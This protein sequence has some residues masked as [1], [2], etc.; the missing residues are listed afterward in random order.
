M[1]A[2]T[3]ASQLGTPAALDAFLRGVER[4]AWVMAHA[5]C[6]DAHGA[7]LA[8]AAT[9][10]RFRHGAA[11]LAMA[12]WP[13]RLWHLLLERPE[14]RRATSGEGVPRALRGLSPGP[15]AILL[16][17]LVV[18]LDE[19]GIARVMAVSPAAV[20]LSM[21]RA[22]QSLPEPTADS[23]ASV[24][25]ELQARVRA[26][27]SDRTR[28]LEALRRATAGD[29]RDQPLP[30]APAPRPRGLMVAL[31]TALV[32][33][34]AGFA[35]TF[36]WPLEPPLQPGEVRELPPTVPVA[37]TPEAAAL[38]SPDFDAAMDEASEAVLDDLLF[39]SW[40][41]AQQE[42]DSDAR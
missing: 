42:A 23:L 33:V 4:R 15:R 1:P 41:A 30:S 10:M 26:L 36:V 35:A 38:A 25:G 5:Q 39:L 7:E 6:G 8:L 20:R 18:G 31:W 13:T 9:L 24:H 19:H 34:V 22:I 12:D 17:R 2:H 3:D 32:L 21:A 16:M 14:L 29:R 28:R 27:P 40:L 37:L 11:D